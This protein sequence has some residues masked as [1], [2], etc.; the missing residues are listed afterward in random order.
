MIGRIVAAGACLLAALAIVAVSGQ[1]LLNE[2]L[3]IPLAGY[4]LEVSAGM[5]LKLLAAR[6]ESEE[7]LPYP[8]VLTVYG[9]I[10]GM[11]GS[12]KAGEYEIASGTTPRGL[13]Q[14]LVE[15]RVKLHSLTIIEGWTITDLMRAIRQNVAI[16]QTLPPGSGKALAK[17]LGL[18]SADPEGWFFP[19]T[20]RFAR[21]TTDREI[22]AMANSRMKILLDQAWAGRKPEI[23]LHSRYDALILASIIE[24]ETA[25]DRERPLI[26]GVFT[27][28]LK[29]GMRLQTDPTV[30]YGLGVDFNGDLTRRHLLKDTPYNTYT[31]AGLP[32]T[33]IALPG[34][35]ALLAAVQPD[36]SDAL[37]FVA[38]GERDGSHVFSTTLRDH[39]AAVKRYLEATRATD[40]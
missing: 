40:K 5:S 9:R 20:Y 24:R 8:A 7:V 13:L 3:N 1:R 36:D 39:N 33:P 30:I 18:D 4:S 28:R 2:P 19:D 11:A 15:G 12:I 25:L 10:S 38:S 22:L 35:S 37:Y 6:L 23:P 34:E 27:R 29:A 26:A 21:G 16:R 17:A 32:P 14:Q 31:R